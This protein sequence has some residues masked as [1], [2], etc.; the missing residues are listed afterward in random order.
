[1]STNP[2]QRP[3]SSDS[4]SSNNSQT[5]SPR[6]EKLTLTALIKPN[7][8]L[9]YCQ[10]YRI[11]SMY[12]GLQGTE[13]I[14]SDYECLLNK[15]MGCF[16]IFLT[17]EHEFKCFTKST[18]MNMYNFACTNECTKLLI[19]MENSNPEVKKYEQMFSVIDA[20]KESDEAV[21]K[22]VFED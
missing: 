11:N 3:G 15:N 16:T 7:G 1:M 22:V 6:L 20:F 13:E 4:S 17:K 8:P 19:V 10:T 5:K 2:A 21:Q 18:L 14:L 9:A 12:P